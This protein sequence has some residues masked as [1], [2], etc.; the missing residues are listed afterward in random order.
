VAWTV[1]MLL[2]LRRSK[3]HGEDFLPMMLGRLF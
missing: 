3:K 1:W 2:A